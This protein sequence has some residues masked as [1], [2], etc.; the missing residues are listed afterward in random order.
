MAT[1]K[2]RRIAPRLAVQF[3]CLACVIEGQWL[4][5][6]QPSPPATTVSTEFSRVYIFVDKAGLVGHQ[7]AVE[8]KLKQGKLSFR[9]DAAGALVFDM[10]SFEVDTQRA[11]KYIGLEG[12]IDASTQS[13]TNDNMLGAEVLDVKRFPEAKIENV[14]FQVQPTKSQRGLAEYLLV[15]DFTLQSKTRR[16][17]ALCDHEMQNG[18]HHVRGSFKIKQTDF[19]MKP[20]SK[21][22]GAVGVA[23][24]LVIHG[25]LW[26][27]PE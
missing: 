27:V 5:A 18:W 2:S 17:E 9:T 21:M 4:P 7:H 15:G 26:I 6:Q 8:G 14:T 13:K 25:D 3:L 22:M 16:I 19:G 20:F 1:A 11:R 12:T 24:E 23:D 10:N